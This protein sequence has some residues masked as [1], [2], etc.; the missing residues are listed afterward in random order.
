MER[1][2]EMN[3]KWANIVF[4]TKKQAAELLQV[5]PRSIELYSS[6]N[7]FPTIRI[8]SRKVLYPTKDVLQW[9]KQKMG[10]I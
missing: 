5:S 1:F 7:N 3:P 10:D 9:L 6:K 4:L 2:N 8:S